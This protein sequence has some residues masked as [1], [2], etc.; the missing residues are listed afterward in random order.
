MVDEEDIPNGTGT[1]QRKVSIKIHST[2]HPPLASLAAKL[3]HNNE[4]NG[5]E[6]RSAIVGKRPEPIAASSSRCAFFCASGYDTIARIN[7][8]TA[9]TVYLG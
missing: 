8:E 5:N 2:G 1:A 7:S 3:V 4:P 9:V 6:D